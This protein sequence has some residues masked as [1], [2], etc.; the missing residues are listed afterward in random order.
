MIDDP[1]IPSAVQF[2]SATGLSLGVVLVMVRWAATFLASRHDVREAHLDASHDRLIK[3]LETQIE[4]LTERFDK[5]LARIDS[6]E[7]ELVECRTRHAEAEAELKGLR[8]IINAQ[9]SMRQEA[10]V[11]IAAD[12]IARKSRGH[13]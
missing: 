13:E 9:G 2:G 11:L 12:K 4:S 10:Q 3:T 5:A 6:V 7:A 1:L 8:A